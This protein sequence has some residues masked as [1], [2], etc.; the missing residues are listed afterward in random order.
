MR[1]FMYAV[2]VLATVLSA[3][4]W[5]FVLG[6]MRAGA[7]APSVSRGQKQDIL[8]VPVELP[9]RV[10][11]PRAPVLTA[12]VNGETWSLARGGQRWVRLSPVI[13]CQRWA[14]PRPL[15]AGVAGNLTQ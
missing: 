7:G 2:A 3:F 1:W 11:P 5:V 15:P 12:C 9:R 14:S 6:Q 10:P 4:L 8:S 13:P